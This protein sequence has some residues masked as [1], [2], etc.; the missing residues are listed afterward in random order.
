MEEY[1]DINKYIKKSMKKGGNDSSL[2]RY[3]SSDE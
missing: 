1:I 3:L 2:F